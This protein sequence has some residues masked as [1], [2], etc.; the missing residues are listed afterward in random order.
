M[1]ERGQLS[2]FS[3]PFSAAGAVACYSSS[4][5]LT[6]FSFPSLNF[7]FAHV[8]L[9][10]QPAASKEIEMGKKDTRR[11][12]TLNSA[13]RDDARGWWLKDVERS[14]AATRTVGS[15]ARAFAFCSSCS[16]SIRYRRSQGLVL[17]Y[18]LF[19]HST[20]FPKLG[21]HAATDLYPSSNKRR[22]RNRTMYI[23]TCYSC[24]LSHF[25]GLGRVQVRSSPE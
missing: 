23:S 14:T 18:F 4:S 15:L 11:I 21:T 20:C 8:A 10:E 6:F 25:A 24:C 16:F 22:K 5:S 12:W 1:V 7:R 3:F 13:G 17:S 2:S 9:A 19:Y